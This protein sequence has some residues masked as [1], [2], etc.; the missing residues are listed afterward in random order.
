M[1]TDISRTGAE[2]ELAA[3]VIELVR[4]VV[5]S[6]AQA[7]VV[8]WHNAEALTRFANS[9]I[10]QNVADAT[11]TVRLRMH[12]DGRTAG[13]STTITSADGLRALV[14]RT[15]EAVRLSPADPTWPPWKRE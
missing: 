12:L 8:V 2:L 14:E 10:H 6:A 5:G 13:G 15:V 11:T 1:T 3:R 7:E 4:S 9:A